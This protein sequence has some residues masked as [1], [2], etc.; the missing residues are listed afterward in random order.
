MDE[1]KRFC[2]SSSSKSHD[3]WEELLGLARQA[4]PPGDGDWTDL[5]VTVTNLCGY[6][7]YNPADDSDYDPTEEFSDDLVTIP[8]EELHPDPGTQ[9]YQSVL[10]RCSPDEP[11]LA[12]VRDR[13]RHLGEANFIKA[14]SRLYCA[15]M[16][17]GIGSLNRKSPNREILGAMIWFP[18]AVPAPELTEALR[19]LAIWSLEH[20]TAQA[21]TIGIVL[22]SMDSQHAAGALRMIEIAAK[23]QSARE[24]FG[25]FASHVESKAGITP[26]ISAERFVPTLGLDVHG[27]ARTEFPGTGAA[28]LSIQG[29][30][31]ILS[32]YN[33]AGKPVAA[34]P[35]AMKRE[36]GDA[37]KELRAT[38]KGLGKLLL[39]Q[40]DRLENLVLAPRSWEFAAWH[41]LYLEHPIVGAVARRL[42]W[43]VDGTPLA[44]PD[45]TPVDVRGKAPKVSPKSK[46]ELWH[47]I[48]QPTAA[49]L[50]WRER[51]AALNI[52]Q[53]FKQAHREV[54]LL[55]DAERRT[56]TYSNRFAAHILRQQQFRALAPGRKWKAPFLGGWDAGDS[57]SAERLLPDGWRIEFWINA[58]TDQT[59][60]T[61]AFLHVATDQVRFYRNPRREPAPLDQVPDRIFSEAMRDVDL[62]VGVTSV[63]NDPNWNDSGDAVGHRDYWNRFT[64]GELGA[65]A[66]TRRE[67]LQRLIPRLKIASLCSFTDRHLVVRG[68]LRNYRIHLGSANILMEPNDA[69][70]CIVADRRLAER[71]EYFL[72][73]EGDSTLSLILSK[74]FLLAEDSKITDPSIVSQIKAR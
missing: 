40:R 39:N 4:R 46:V 57:D 51:L 52:T 67:A 59:G 33:A 15:A 25:R 13:A 23:R 6:P 63:G 10:A 37:V 45:N 3:C 55:T 56:L 65:T 29:T 43:I 5:E 66:A 35:A 27:K 47:P 62:F 72:P 61:G 32:L 54:Y 50:A 69:Y 2:E 1:L 21:K 16:Q 11:W 28:E 24:R 49:V 26:E 58:V 70:L 60:P 31:G 7:N 20:N 14:F 68:Q 38:A 36:H 44:F 12:R 30:K 18:A 42:I 48:G 8:G 64:F 53:P 9:D 22:A 73:F 71:E 34:I 74:A 17:S 19:Q 41:K